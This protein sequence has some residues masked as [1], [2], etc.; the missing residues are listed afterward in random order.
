MVRANVDMATI[1]ASLSRR[2]AKICVSLFGDRFR[3]KDDI[4]TIALSNLNPQN[5]MGIVLC[6]LTRIERGEDWCQN[7]NITPT[8]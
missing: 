8:V 3:F 5:H 6:N 1:P 2:A 4:L 7:T